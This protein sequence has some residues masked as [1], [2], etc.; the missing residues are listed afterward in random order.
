[1]EAI[2]DLI[3]EL[4]LP[5]TSDRTTLGG[6]NCGFHALIQQFK[7]PNVNI[8]YKSHFDLR[9]QVCNFALTSRNPKLIKM[10]DVHDTIAKASGSMTWDV[11][12]EGMKK[13]GEYMT[14]PVLPVAAMF[15]EVN[16]NVIS[17]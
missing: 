12:F 16:V 14:G 7:R 10:K 5:L 11:L 3:T 13:K 2:L 15:L 17:R 4:E 8:A 9:S 1:M 6:G